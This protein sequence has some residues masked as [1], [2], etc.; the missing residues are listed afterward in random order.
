MPG[1][2]EK[3]VK[4]DQTTLAYPGFCFHA[5]LPLTPLGT[6]P[7]LLRHSAGRA[8]AGLGPLSRLSQ[9]KNIHKQQTRRGKIRRNCPCFFAVR[10]RRDTRMGVFFALKIAMCVR[11]L[12]FDHSRDTWRSKNDSCLSSRYRVVSTTVIIQAYVG[13]A[14]VCSRSRPAHDVQ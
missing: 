3:A 6:L 12:K 4:L 10:R 8:H 11:Q 14:W 7:S 1:C 9:K 2:F 5:G 13:R